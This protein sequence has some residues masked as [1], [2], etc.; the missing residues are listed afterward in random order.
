MLSYI[1]SE[2]YK[3]FNSK[4]IYLNIGIFMGLVIL[5]NSVLAITDKTTID[6]QYATTKFSFGMLLDFLP[7]ISMLCLILVLTVSPNELKYKTLKNSISYGVT[8]TQI[9]IGKT[10]VAMACSALCLVLVSLIYIGSAYLLLDDSGP[11]YLVNFIL[12]LVASIPAF[13]A[14]L[15]LGIATLL[16]FSNESLIWTIWSTIMIFIPIVINLLGMKFNLFNQLGNW[17]LVIQQSST[18]NSGGPTVHTFMH[19]S[20]NLFRYV[21]SGL[22]GTLIFFILGLLAF[23]KK[24]LN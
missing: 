12:T 10:I 7:I 16:I 19:S 21:A 14:S 15:T 1:K 17:L 3:V 22:L 4:A 18:I 11:Q 20:D 6:F 24:D 2:F 13:L 23:R 5:M 9:Y 8:R